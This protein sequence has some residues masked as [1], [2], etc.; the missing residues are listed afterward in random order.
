MVPAFFCTFAGK[1]QRSEMAIPFGKRVCTPKSLSR[2]RA[3]KTTLNNSDSLR[4]NKLIANLH[5]GRGVS[6]TTRSPFLYVIVDIF[7]PI[8][9]RKDKNTVYYENS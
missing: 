6:L 4:S 7:L 3:V 9:L 8:C 5:K 1:A 2:L